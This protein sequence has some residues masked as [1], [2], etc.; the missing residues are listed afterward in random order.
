MELIRSLQPLLE[1]ENVIL[2]LD[3]YGVMYNGQSVFDTV[4]PILSYCDEHGIPFFM[5]TNNATQSIDVILDKMASYNINLSEDQI[6]SSGCGCYF[7]DDIK[8]KIE[9]KNVYVYGYESSRE[10]P[11][12]AGAN[13]VD[14]PADADTILLMASLVNHNH[15]TYKSVHQALKDDPNKSVICLNPDHYVYYQSRY[16]PVMGYYA[17]QLEAQLGLTFQWVGKPFSTF[18]DIVKVVFKSKNYD[19]SNLVF[20]DDNP[21]N[22]RRMVRDLDCVGCVITDTG[23]YPKYRHFENVDSKIFQLSSCKL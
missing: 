23:I 13:L 5:M 1:Q 9:H 7:L 12:S 10:Y 8:E 16:M 19:T 22:V 21:F 17:A 4:P 14:D 18:S 15:R 20:C 11:K 6:I 2:G 3:A